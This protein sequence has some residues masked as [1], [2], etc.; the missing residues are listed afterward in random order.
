MAA[1]RDKI[2]YSLRDLAH[3]TDLSHSY[4]GDIESGR[5]QPPADTIRKIAAGLDVDV[6]A[7][8]YGPPDLEQVAVA[9]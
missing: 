7:I 4:L 1:L 6:A 5:R 9:G 2:G 8:V 3:R